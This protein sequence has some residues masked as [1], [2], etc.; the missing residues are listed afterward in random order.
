MLAKADPEKFS[1]RAEKRGHTPKRDEREHEQN[2]PNEKKATGEVCGGTQE[3]HDDTVPRGIQPIGPL[4]R[5][6]KA[7]AK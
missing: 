7:S 4:A 1:V 5:K 3:L 6:A 2:S